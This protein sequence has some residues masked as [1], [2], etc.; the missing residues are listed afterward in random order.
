MKGFIY[1]E[2][3]VWRPGDDMHLTFVLEDKHDA[4]PARHPVTMELY[5]PKGQMLE[6]ITNI[7]CHLKQQLYIT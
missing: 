1:A 4:I 6:S 7:E 5:N 3:G 2:R